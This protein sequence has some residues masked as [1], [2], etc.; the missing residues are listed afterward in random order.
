MIK[1]LTNI[2]VIDDDPFVTD[3]LK[4]IL[5]SE[6]YSVETVHCGTE[7]IKFIKKNRNVQLIL[8]DM[9]MP[10]INGL[11]LIPMLKAENADIPI[12]I[13]TGNNEISIAIKAMQSGA[14]DYLLKDENIQETVVVAVK[15]MLEKYQ[16]KI[17]LAQKNT[18]LELK[19]KELIESNLLKNNFLGI[20][21]HDMRTPLYGIKGL[22]ELLL[23]GSKGKMADDQI[24]YIS[25]INHSV[26]EMLLLINDLLDISKIESGK[27]DILPRNDSLIALIDNRLQF[28]SVMASKKNIIIQ[29]N[30]LPINTFYFDANRISQVF[31]NFMSN[32]IKYSPFDK[33]IIVSTET[34][35]KEVIV[36][37]QDQGPGISQEDQEK[38]FGEFQRLSARPT[39]GE[40]SV[41]LGLAIVKKIITAHKGRLEVKSELDKG[42]RFSF[43]LPYYGLGVH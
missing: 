31:D 28:H 36:H 25:L 41:G 26:E 32:A 12:M 10:D 5:E 14:S 17:D 33:E 9:N 27:L 24:A 13:L 18:E 19:N 37:I 15:R 6:D 16:L 11:E 42:S 4:A 40:K 35:E 3:M 39:G 43:A 30:F 29:R 1:E 22:A 20:A 2:L 23:D 7:A 38:L 8:S 21:A 34:T